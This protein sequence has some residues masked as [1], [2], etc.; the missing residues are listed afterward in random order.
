MGAIRRRC[1]PCPAESRQYP[2]GAHASGALAICPS[3]RQRELSGTGA[4]GFLTQ[5]PV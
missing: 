4:T 3:P 1:Y 5:Q 2:L